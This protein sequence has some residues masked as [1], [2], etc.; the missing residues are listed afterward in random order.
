MP[1][2]AH[3]GTLL[4]VTAA[5]AGV[6]VLSVSVPISP[7]LA[8]AIHTTPGSGRGAEPHRTASIVNTPDLTVASPA[9]AVAAVATILP[10]LAASPH[11]TILI[12]AM[13]T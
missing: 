3:P 6:T 5:G 10:H 7:E 9:A 1:P 8:L 13:G 11:I 12:F 4:P 2:A